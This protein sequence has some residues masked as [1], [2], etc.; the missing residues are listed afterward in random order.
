MVI[1]HLF[2]NS[3]CFLT[4]SQLFSVDLIRFANYVPL[5]QNHATCCNKQERIARCPPADRPAASQSLALTACALRLAL[6]LTNLQVLRVVPCQ[7]RSLY[8]LRSQELAMYASALLTGFRHS[9]TSPSHTVTSKKC[10]EHCFCTASCPNTLSAALLAHPA[11]LA[12][13]HIPTLSARAI[14][15]LAVVSGAPDRARHCGPASRSSSRA[16]I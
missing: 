15:V 14:P 9:G 13:S 10:S 6:Q 1:S 3:G 2:D 7:Q 4:E 11:P 16:S 8:C 5:S 12:W